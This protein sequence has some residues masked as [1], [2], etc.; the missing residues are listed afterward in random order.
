MIW[1]DNDMD[2]HDI[3]IGINVNIENYLL[4]ELGLVTQKFV[5]T[6]IST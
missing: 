3:D 5:I 4:D 6:C 1:T 2:R